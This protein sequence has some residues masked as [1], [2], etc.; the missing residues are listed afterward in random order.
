MPRTLLSVAGAQ[1]GCEAAPGDAVVVYRSQ[2]L[3]SA[4]DP[5][6]ISSCEGGGGGSAGAEVGELG[7]VVRWLEVALE[8]T[9]SFGEHMREGATGEW[10]GYHC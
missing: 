10:L 8:C 4:C 2:R 9:V 1:R 7:F 3:G 5:V 6:C